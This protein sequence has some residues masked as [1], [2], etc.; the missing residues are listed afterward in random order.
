MTKAS[1]VAKKKQQLDKQLKLVC[2]ETG[3]PREKDIVA[4]VR[5]AVRKAWMRAP[6]KLSLLMKSAVHVSDVPPQLRPKRLTANSKWLYKCELEG[7][8][9]IASDI[10]VDHKVG[11]HS[12]KCYDDMVSFTKGI[13]D[14]SWDDLSVVSKEAHA[15][16]TYSERYGVSYEEAKA[17]KDVI[18]VTKLTAVKQKKW[19]TDR[20]VKPAS[21]QEGRTKQITGVLNKES[22]NLK[23]R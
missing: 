22:I 13:L 18:A 1:D 20:G 4:V 5:S 21:N 17:L 14:V 15:I 7:T 10:E 19:L 12:L 8:Y 3:K 6:T 11:E 2:N 9:H 16:K 23:E